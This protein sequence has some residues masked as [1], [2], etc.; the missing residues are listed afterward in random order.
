MTKW[1]KHRVIPITLLIG[2]VSGC[3]LGAF[4]EWWVAIIIAIVFIFLLPVLMD[5]YKLKDD[6]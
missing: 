2:Y 3:L 1:L 5:F 6:E 4:S